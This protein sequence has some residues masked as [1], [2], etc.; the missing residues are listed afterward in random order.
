[1]E[2]P[3]ALDRDRLTKLLALTTSDNDHE[4]LVALRMA[5]ELLKREKLSW[6]EVLGNEGRT[7]RVSITREP[8][9]ENW[10]A[11]HLRDKVVIETMFRA[12][13]AT[14]APGDNGDFW[15]FL[16]SV[17][18]RWATHGAL[19]QGQYQALKNCYN[20]TLKTAK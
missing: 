6:V 4:A 15:G 5:N 16:A 13:V 18:L 14:R 17:K 12:I 19:T 1:M 9:D 2:L 11:P 10:I 3:V 7:V 20:R 8:V